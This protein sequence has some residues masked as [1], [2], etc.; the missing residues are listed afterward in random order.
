MEQVTLLHTNDLHGH[1]TPAAA[2][3][4]QARREA[5]GAVLLD[6]GDALGTGNLG[7]RPGGE[8]VQRLMT[9]AGYAAGAL[10]NREFHL[11][12]YG[13][14]C[15]LKAAGFPLLCTNLSGR[16]VFGEIPDHVVLEPRP[17][18]RLWIF[19]LLRDMVGGPP[20]R[21]LSGA[22]FAPPVAIAADQVAQAAAAGCAACL[23]LSHLGQ[24]ADQ[25]LAGDVPGLAIILGGHSHTVIDPPVQVEGCWIGQNRPYGESVTR[26]QLSVEE[27]RLAEVTATVEPWPA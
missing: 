1:L 12:G 20:A 10:G 19:S 21:W 23:C 4:L 18:L 15:K 11:W 2:A 14:R 27:G 13:Q 24:N 7:F 3:A 6:S 26:Y 25:R 17:G 16:G 22:R 9:T 5:L 8:P